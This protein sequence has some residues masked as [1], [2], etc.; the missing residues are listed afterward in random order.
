MVSSPSI[1]DL[2]AV[3]ASLQ[4]FDEAGMP[5]LCHKSRGL[6]SYLS[7]LL[8]AE[9]LDQSPW[10]EPDKV[11][12]WFITPR[13]LARR[14]AQC[15]LGWKDRNLLDTVAGELERHGILVDIKG[16]NIMRLTPVPL[17]NTYVEIWETVGALKAALGEA[18]EP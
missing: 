3:T 15:S 16:P 12:F 6:S 10:N 2:T 5:A 17:I 8:Q 9:I 13:D 18:K 14:G 1:L 11:P 4:L 7:Q